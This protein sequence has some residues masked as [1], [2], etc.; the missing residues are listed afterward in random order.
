MAVNSASVMSH[1][2]RIELGFVTRVGETGLSEFGKEC[3]PVEF[4][5]LGNL[6]ELDN[7]ESAFAAFVFGHERLWPTQ[8]RGEFSLTDTGRPARLDQEEA[9]AFVSFREDGFRHTRAPHLLAHGL[10]N[11]SQDKPKTG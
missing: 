6:K 1:R 3:S 5:G 11:R 9:K 7:I 10:I 2:V 4:Q 8:L